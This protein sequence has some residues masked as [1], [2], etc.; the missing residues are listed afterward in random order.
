MV[1]ETGAAVWQPLSGMYLKAPATEKHWKCIAEDFEQ[2][3][4]LPH[5]VGA[6][7]VE[8]IAIDCP[9]YGGSLH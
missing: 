4:D 9:Q 7:D 2:E 8:H 5:V 6:A 1:W 3:W